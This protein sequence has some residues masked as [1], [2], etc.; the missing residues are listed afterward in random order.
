MTFRLNNQK[1]LLTYKTHLPKEETIQLFREKIA[2]NKTIKFIRIAHETGHEDTDY[3]HSHLL[4]D[5]GTA[6]QSTNARIF[7]LNVK[8]EGENVIVHPNILPIKSSA[9]WKNCILYIAKEDPEN[10]DLLERKETLPLTHRIAECETLKEALDMFVKKPNDIDGIEKIYNKRS[11]WIPSEEPAFDW[12]FK[13]ADGSNK[14]HDWQHYVLK[15]ITEPHRREILWI[16][17]RVG[18]TGKSYLSTYLDENKKALFIDEVGKKSDFS[19]VLANEVKNGWDMRNLIINL[20]RKAEMFD[21]FYASL[22]SVKDGKIASMKFDSGLLKLHPKWNGQPYKNGLGTNI[23]VFAN[24]PP[25]VKSLS[26]DRW[27]VFEIVKKSLPVLI[28]KCIEVLPETLFDNVEEFN[29]DDRLICTAGNPPEASKDASGGCCRTVSSDLPKNELFPPP[30]GIP[31]RGNSD[32]EDSSILEEFTSSRDSLTLQNRKYHE[33]LINKN[34]QDF[35][36]I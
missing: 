5:F 22:E 18:N 17:D 26:E 25:N 33:L 19:R 2:F 13:N 6:F 24:F 35:E 30:N 9:H 31:Q 3:Y 34:S 1:L 12:E 20:P 36:E 29:I 14:F 16:Y 7:D 32:S 15:Y 23:I 4:V 27:N 21:H 28:P 11:L 8:D 10:S